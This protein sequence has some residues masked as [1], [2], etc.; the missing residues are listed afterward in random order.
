M[1]IPIECYLHIMAAHRIRNTRGFLISYRRDTELKPGQRHC[2]M[3]CASAR[4]PCSN[5]QDFF[6]DVFA[7]AFD[8]AEVLAEGVLVVAGALFCVALA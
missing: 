8:V 6:A 4:Q 7:G 2:L 1:V 5:N 3:C